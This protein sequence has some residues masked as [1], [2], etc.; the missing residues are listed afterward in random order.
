MPPFQLES[1]DQVC[2]TKFPCKAEVGARAKGFERSASADPTQGS[3]VK[4][5]AGA[6]SFGAGQRKQRERFPK[7]APPLRYTWPWISSRDCRCLS[8]DPKVCLFQGPSADRGASYYPA[9]ESRAA[10][11]EESRPAPRY[12][13]VSFS[14]SAEAILDN[15]MIIRCLLLPPPP[16]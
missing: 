16:P 4:R 11:G 5:R 1:K 2:K 7:M 3:P 9:G 10:A 6:L 15:L 13:C 14:R 8:R 12:F